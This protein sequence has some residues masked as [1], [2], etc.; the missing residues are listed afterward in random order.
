M[1]RIFF[2]TLILIPVTIAAQTAITGK[3]TDAQTGAPLS[4]VKVTVIEQNISTQTNAEGQFTFS[5]LDAGNVEISFSLEGYF[6][7]IKMAHLAENRSIDME[8][9]ALK[10]DL[11]SET[12][13]DVVLQM[14]EQQLEDEAGNHATTGAFSAQTDVYLSQTGYNFSPMRFRTRGYDNSYESTYI[15]GVHF[16]DAER[17][18]FNYSAIGGLNNATRNKDV[19]YGL[20]PSAFTYGNIGANTNINTRASAIAAG[21]N[22]SIAL[23]NRNYNFRAQ[24][25][26]GTGILQN[27]WAFAVSGVLRW[28]TGKLPIADGT[29]YNSGGL[30]FS[31][32]KIINSNHS[33]ALTLMGAPTRR[34]GQSALTKEVRDLTGSIYYNPAWGLQNGKERNSRIVESFDPTLTLTHEWKISETQ[35]LRTGAGFH[36]SF[37][38]N[39]AFAY[40]GTHPSPDYYRNMPSFQTSDEWT[41]NTLTDLWENDEYTRQIKWDEL[42]RAN[43]NS[44]LYNLNTVIDSLQAP[45]VLE[46]RHNDLMEGI[47]NSVYSN[48]LT[49]NLKITAGIEARLSQGKHYKTIEDLLGAKYYID[50]DTYAERDLTGGTL[51]DADKSM[52]Q[53]DLRNPNRIVKEGDTFGYNYDINA[54]TANAFA[55]VEYNWNQLFVYLAGK[56][57]YTSFYRYGFMDNGRAAWL[58]STGREN[59]KSY[60]K[61]KTWYFVDPSLKGGFMYNIDNRSRLSFN[62]LAETRAPLVQD[63]YV[64]E[65]VKDK[66]APNLKSQKILSMDLNYTFNYKP[67][68]GRIGAFRTV[69]QDAIDKYGYYDDENRTF[70]NHLLSGYDK[71]YQ[72]IELGVAVPVTTWLTVEAAGT[73]A[74]YHFMSDATGIKSTENGAFADIT[75]TILTKG[76]KINNGP[77]LASTVTLN[78]FYKMWF[79]DATLNYFDNNYLDFAP[80]RFSESNQ[81][82]FKAAGDEVYQKLGTQEK[83]KGGFMLN[84][85]L[86]KLIYLKNRKSLSVNLSVSN[87]LN[88]MDLITGGYQQ[89]RIPMYSDSGT[90]RLNTKGLD[91]FPNKYYYAWGMNCFLNIGY[92]F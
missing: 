31:A 13:Q 30:L 58:N 72:G 64:S 91:L 23:T 76:L 79:F 66:I 11:A 59:V 48:N 84:A 77:Q 9:T 92:K 69:I 21:H 37:Y 17:G 39:S 49:K 18:G 61:S 28:S 65:R 12:K 45:Y 70:V 6:P 38:S 47:L 60:G 85:S 36:Y 50:I 33:I 73:Y 14:S 16:V 68:R 43:E 25:T 89:A 29:F 53:N 74:D 5:Y 32:E 19:V 8:A 51:Q 87:I 1:R 75:E 80:N 78:F 56:G 10:P 52:I 88:N 82:M 55:Q 35:R 27:G 41:K 42:Y 7:Q 63:V 90:S 3:V 15:N 54:L 67:I 24:Y 34:A 62:I 81:S 83:L 44:N 71:L 86:G 57:T 26:Y 20:T 46:R 4:A 40:N 2:L 22:A